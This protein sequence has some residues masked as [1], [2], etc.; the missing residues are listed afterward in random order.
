MS[1]RIAVLISGKGSNLQ[2]ILDAI[3]NEKLDATVVGVISDKPEAYGLVRAQEAEV[4][5]FSLTPERG[6]SRVLYDQRLADLLNSLSPDLIV[7]A[8][9]MRILSPHFVKSFEGKIINIHPSLL[10]KYPGLHTHQQVLANKDAEHGCTIH[11]V[12]DTLDGGPVIAQC[13]VPVKKYDTLDSLQKRVHAREHRLY[14]QVI[15]WFAHQRIQ[16]H[17]DRVILNEI[18]LPRE[19]A[20]V[21]F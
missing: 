10:P 6:E 12:T 14:P 3:A 13:R 4:P 7:L 9:F 21:S 8:G 16:L 15:Q 1:Y 5:V 2:A 17:N 11:F 18:L 19:G 20:Q